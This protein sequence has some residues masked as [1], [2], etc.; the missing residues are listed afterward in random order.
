MLAWDMGKR[1]ECRNLLLA[2]MDKYWDSMSQDYKN[3]VEQNISRIGITDDSQSQ[4]MYDKSNHKTL[5][6]QFNNSQVIEKNYSQVFQ[7]VFVL[8]A[9][10]GKKN[11]T[12]VE[13]GGADPFYRNNTA[14]LEETFGWKGISIEYDSDFSEKYK[15]QRPLTKVINSDAL[16]LDYRKILQENFDTKTIDYLQLDIEPARNTYECL[17]KIPFDEYKFAVIT[18]EH[19]H[20]IDVTKICRE[21]SREYLRSK[22]YI[23]A[24]GDVSPDGYST[25]EDWW[26]HPDLIGEDILA[27]IL[28]S[29]EKIKKI[30]EYMFSKRTKYNSSEVFEPFT[31]E[32]LKNGGNITP[33]IIPSEL[34]NGTGTFNPSIYN[35]NGQL[36]CVVRHCQVT[37][38]HAEKGVFE[39]EWGPL[40]YLHPENDW[41]LTTTNYLLLLNDDLSIKKIH[42]IDMSRFNTPP[43]WNFI[44]LE[45]CRL[46]RWNEKLYICGVRRDTTPNGE[47]RMELSE[48]RISDDTVEEIS[49]YRIPV[50]DGV[51]SYCEKNWMPIVDIP[52]QFVKW[53]T[54]TEVVKVDVEN[55]KTTQ[56]VL[57]N[58]LHLGFKRDLRGSSHVLP[59]KNGHF[60]ITHEVDLYNSPAGR[61][62]G[63]YRHRFVFWDSDWN[64]IKTSEEFKFL[65]AEIEFCAGMTKKGDDYLISFG[66]QDNCAFV[67]TCP[68]KIIEDIFNE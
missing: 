3:L 65:G 1:Q 58:N 16:S 30:D 63:K 42:K 61:K 21:K 39:H 43:I 27:K 36:M 31:K 32:V 60:C 50:V 62:N 22:G 57:T 34:T 20:Y 51:Q 52:Y 49:R 38:F 23:L 33:L 53:C 55:K 25:F 67:L 46:F 11:G 5:R 24:V 8:M 26:V 66:L 29:S 2:L 47:G 56:E 37:I 9:H 15:I 54:E 14:L 41:T 48:I 35:D 40:I 7:D 12:F 19:D 45:D 13:I 28:D 4:I 59:W 17:L 68:E 18:Y 44:G 10:N 6:F 64:I